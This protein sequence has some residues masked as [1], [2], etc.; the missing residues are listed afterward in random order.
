MFDDY[1]MMFFF[2]SVSGLFFRHFISR[3]Y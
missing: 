2:F 1:M 3:A